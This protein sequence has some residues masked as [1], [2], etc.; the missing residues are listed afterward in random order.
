MRI[1]P[2]A[3]PP[4]TSVANAVALVTSLRPAILDRDGA[5][6]DPTEFA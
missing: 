1:D 3:L 4:V 6:L 2:R 5:A